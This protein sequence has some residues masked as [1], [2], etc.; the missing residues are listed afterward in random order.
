MF[1]PLNCSCGAQTNQPKT[2]LDS[3]CSWPSAIQQKK[4]VISNETA[5]TIFSVLLLLLF[6]YHKGTGQMVRHQRNGS[7]REATQ[8]L[9]EKTRQYTLWF[10]KP[11]GWRP[12]DYMRKNT[13]LVLLYCSSTGLLGII[14]W[15]PSQMF[16]LTLH[17]CS[18]YC[19][20]KTAS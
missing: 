7:K 14:S 15:P 19:I 11:Q 2:V 5:S 9:S 8:R 4:E 12:R 3:Y 20:F 1:K 18:H 10:Q 17:N 16:N 13:M 6:Q